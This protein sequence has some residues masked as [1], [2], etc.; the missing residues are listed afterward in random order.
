M[1]LR[2]RRLERQNRLRTLFGTIES[3]ERQEAADVVSVCRAQRP[4]AWLGAQVLVAVR[5][6][7]PALKQKRHVHL[8]AVNAWLDRQAQEAGRLVDAPVQRVDVCAHP[9][10]EHA[11][12]R[13]LVGDGADAVEL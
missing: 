4:V 3:G 12:E 2:D 11:N 8:L 10:S 1:G 13:S 9:A 7:E 6:T 5:E